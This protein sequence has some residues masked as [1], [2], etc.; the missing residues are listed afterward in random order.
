M[1]ARDMVLIGVII[2]AHGIKGEV[3][4]KSFAGEPAAIEGY[5]PLTTPSGKSIEIDRLRPQ[6]DGFIAGLKGVTDRNQAEA[7]NGEEL[8][9]HRSRLP[10]AR[11]GEIYVHDLIGLPVC[12]KDGTP[13]GEVVAVPNFGAGDLLEVKINGRQETVLI[14]FADRFVPEAEVTRGVIIVDLPDGY[15]DDIE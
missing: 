15:L 1:P 5:G 7:L 8:F 14:P 9:V 13:L 4:L 2:G 10:E 12:L 11:P 3:K 6:R